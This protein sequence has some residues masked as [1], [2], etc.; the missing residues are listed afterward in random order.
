MA[1]LL[2]SGMLLNQET[3]ETLPYEIIILDITWKEKLITVQDQVYAQMKPKGTYIK[4]TDQ[5]FEEVLG[6]MGIGVGAIC[7]GQLVG[8]HVSSFHDSE[9]RELGRYLNLEP[10]KLEGLAYVEASVVLPSFRGNGLQKIMIGENIKL[11]KSTGFIKHLVTTVAPENIAS[12]KSLKALGF[13]A[14]KRKEFFPGC[15]RLILYQKLD[16]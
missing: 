8:F 1:V 7:Q 10:N 11:L 13:S 2:A 12:L 9:T 14:L 15:Q 16:K 6:E 3:K 4:I 5:E